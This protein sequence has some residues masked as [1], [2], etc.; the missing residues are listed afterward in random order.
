M[1]RVIALL[2][3][4]NVGGHTV[5][6]DALRGHFTDLGLA[7]VATHIASGNVLFDAQ[8][9]DAALEGRIEAHLRAA[10]GYEVATFLRTD[11]EIAAIAAHQPF[12]AAETVAAFAL[13]VAF[14]KVP[15][16]AAET[17]RLLAY[18]RAS[19]DFIVHGREVYW[20]R[21]AQLSETNFSGATLERALSAP[22]TIRNITTARKL[23]AIVK[24]EE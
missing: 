9:A 10:L 24:N 11:A 6:M 23:A 13:M 7:N 19:D 16:G 12:D 22:A 14:L 18:R 21:R 1:P 2:R 20:L 17:A 5:K 4:I 15:P 8:T 3:A